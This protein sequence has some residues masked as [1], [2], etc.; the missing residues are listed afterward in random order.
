MVFLSYHSIFNPALFS[1]FIGAWAFSM[2]LSWIWSC[3][4][5]LSICLLQILCNFH[6][7]NLGLTLTQCI[8][9]LG[10][11][12]FPSSKPILFLTL[13]LFPPS[14]LMFISNSMLFPHLYLGFGSFTLS[15]CLHFLAQCI[16]RLRDYFKNDCNSVTIHQIIHLYL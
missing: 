13:A 2:C 1:L 14:Q 3:F 10:L 11:E 7:P 5:P 15:K 4:F 9:F 16:N 12:L 6:I 8:Y